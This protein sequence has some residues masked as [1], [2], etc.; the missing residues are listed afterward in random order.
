MARKG[1]VRRSPAAGGTCTRDGM[2]ETETLSELEALLLLVIL[3]EELSADDVV[4]FGAPTSGRVDRKP[5]G[6]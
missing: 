4:E 6:G 5:S 1:T 3:A 2:E